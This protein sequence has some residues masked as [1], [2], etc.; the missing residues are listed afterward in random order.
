MKFLDSVT[1]DETEPH[2]LRSHNV[3]F[4]GII[5]LAALTRADDEVLLLPQTMS[6]GSGNELS[7]ILEESAN[8]GKRRG[9]RARINLLRCSPLPK[10]RAK[11]L[12]LENGHF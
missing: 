1:L 7:D 3:I 11:P 9:W 5:V 2:E 10:S 6:F 8:H 12:C 4:M